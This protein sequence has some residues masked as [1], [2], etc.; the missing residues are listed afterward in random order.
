MGAVV[1]AEAVT[2]DD[3]TVEDS[4]VGV[5]VPVF[6]IATGEGSVGK[7]GV[8]PTMGSGMTAQLDEPVEEVEP[9]PVVSLKDEVVELGV[10][11]VVEASDVLVT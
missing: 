10:W 6:E 4:V 7:T 9:V 8:G 3:E 1:V 11:V 5:I 2:D